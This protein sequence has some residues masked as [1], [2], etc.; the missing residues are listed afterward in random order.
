MTCL[1]PGA[2]WTTFSEDWD[3]AAIEKGFS[4]WADRGKYM[5]TGMEVEQVADAVLYALMQPPGVAVDLLELRPNIPTP[6][7]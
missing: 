6:K 2:V 5:S 4:A 3:P 7:S 1:R